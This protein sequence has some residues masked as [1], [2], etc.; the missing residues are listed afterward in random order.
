MMK[1]G[2]IVGRVLVHPGNSYG[3]LIRM[4]LSFEILNLFGTLSSNYRPSAPPPFLYEV[5]GHVENAAVS[6]IV[7]III[8]V[9]RSGFAGREGRGWAGR[10]C[11]TSWCTTAAVGTTSTAGRPAAP[12]AGTTT[13]SCRT[14]SGPKTTR[15]K[16][17]PPARVS[18]SNRLARCYFLSR[19]LVFNFGVC[20]EIK[21]IDGCNL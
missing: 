17:S 8:I 14:S 7:I 9:L 11:S 20:T 3:F 15:T 19:P 16:R 5:V 2:T 18:R 6:A 4:C 10:V 12:A 21:K 1:Q 13:A